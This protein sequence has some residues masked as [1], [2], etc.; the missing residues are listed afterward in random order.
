[1]SDRNPTIPLLIKSTESSE[2]LPLRDSD[3]IQ[4]NILAGFL[5]DH[6]SFL[7]LKF[8]DTH[9]GREWLK[10]LLPHIATT[11]QVAT[12][13]T[14]FSNA[15]RA[16][17]GDDPTGL[18]AWWVNIGFTYHGLVT[19]ARDVEGDLNNSQFQLNAFVEGPGARALLLGDVSVSDPSNWLI[20]GPKQ[21]PIDI[22]LTIAAD[23]VSDLELKLN[24][25]RSLAAR[26]EIIVIFEQRGDTLPGNRKGHEHFGFKDGISQPGIKGFDPV[27]SPNNL[28]RSEV[29]GR[30]GSQLINAGEFVLGYDREPVE[31]GDDGSPLHSPKWMKDGSFQVFRRLVQDVP[32]W[33]AQILDQAGSL[34]AAEPISPDLLAAKLIG[35]W[36]SGTPLTEAPDQDIRSAKDRQQDNNFDFEDDPLGERVPQFSHI[37]KMNPRSRIFAPEKRRI[38]R[39]GIP[40]GLP[41][42]PAS[43]RG[44]GIDAERGLLFNAYMASIED[45]FEFLQRSWANNSGFPPNNP[46]N[47]QAG[48]DPVIGGESG[49]VTLRRKGAATT[50]LDFRRFV[51]TSGAVYAFAPSLSTLRL[52]AKGELKSCENNL[53]SA[54]L[55]YPLRVDPIP[56]FDP[57]QINDIFTD[58]LFQNIFEGL[59]T[60]DYNDQLAPC[61][62]N[63][64]ESGEDGITYTFYLQPNAMFHDP[65]LRPVLAEDVKYSFERALWPETNSGSAFDFLGGIVGA[66]DV[67]DGRTR[68]LSGIKI[69]NA[70]TLSITLDHPRGY[71]LPALS[72]SCCWIVCKE[73]IEANGGILDDKAAI[74]TGPFILD[75]FESG[76]YV[77]LKANRHYYGGGPY[78]ERIER[79]V[80]TDDKQARELFDNDEIDICYINL[81]DYIALQQ[82]P[83][84]KKEAHLDRWLDLVYLVMH[85]GIESAFQDTRVRMAIAKA[86]DRDEIVRVL[87]QGYWIR[88]DDLFP[89]KIP[90]D[91]EAENLF[92]FDPAAASQL[93]AE[94]GYEYGNGFPKLTLV[95]HVDSQQKPISPII[96]DHLKRYLHIDVEVEYLESSTYFA[97]RDDQKLAFYVGGMVADYPDPQIVISNQ[98]RS[99]SEHNKVGYRNA[100]FDALCN[101]A[102][103]ELDIEKRIPLYQKAERIARSEVAVLPL[104]HGSFQWLQKPHILGF[105]YNSINFQAHRR[106]RIARNEQNILRYVHRTKEFV[107]DPHLINDVFNTELFQNIYEGLVSYDYNNELV[108]ELARYWEISENGRTY[109]FH[110]R[111]DARFHEPYDRAITSADVKYSLER[112]LSRDVKS[113]SAEMLK[114]IE[115]AEPFMAGKTEGLDGVKILDEQTLSITLDQP[116]N[117]FPGLLNLPVSWVLCREAI[118]ADGGQITGRGI[119]GTGPFRLKQLQKD[120][121]VLVANKNYHQDPPYIKRIERPIVVDQSEERS[122]YDSGQ[123]DICLITISDYL[124]AKEDA[125]LAGEAHLYLWADLVY[126]VMHSRLQAEF[127]DQDVRLAFAKAIDRDAIIY[128]AGRGTWQ[129]ADSILPQVIRGESGSVTNMAYDPDA[130]RYHLAKAGFPKGGGFP[131]LALIHWNDPQL[132]D[133]A[134]MIAENIIQN[135]GIDVALYEKEASDYFSAKTEGRMPFYL[136]GWIADYLDP[137]NFLSVILRTGASQNQVGYSNA[138]FDSLCDKAD[139]TFDEAERRRLYI[140][141]EQMA[142]EDVAILPLLSG[143]F[144]LLIKPYIRGFSYNLLNLM[145]H[146]KTRIER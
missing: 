110:L 108:P 78:L 131:A 106:T 2:D 122:L 138:I 34:P 3:E 87:G 73:A 123:I 69:L 71:F 112:A 51:H 50:K 120:R 77:N 90:G 5:K 39:R 124:K 134:R 75:K 74:G 100:Q 13:N 16:R 61:L 55:R 99:D 65:F 7:F 66:G 88:A 85:P 49:S 54:I 129:R 107:V 45:Q 42:D 31:R 23:E 29:F 101:E 111:P 72:T 17:G 125:A 26:Y 64:W 96:A 10:E 126:L 40:Y 142:L 11:R 14:Q 89:P 59:L 56:S 47:Q 9:S 1:M 103:A 92:A 33:W 84:L 91:R 52:I 95:G 116:R 60:F 146:K 8:T 27:G 38:L 12:F 102:D 136:A 130:A 76:R 128:A 41:F 67:R 22:I 46:P 36:R 37:R 25:M 28:E 83:V 137:H 18:A 4:G 114:V 81:S 133:I 20:G 53:P 115:G 143:N 44:Q 118:E 79:P 104:L 62:A 113:P 144:K 135:L 24:E 121:A 140:Q 15:R 63:R 6:Q 82:N 21:Q 86:I 94:A 127:A 109:I 43:G 117:Y 58:E 48:P 119:I 35:R 57:T 97:S 145:P 141:A 93:L 19:L 80:I 98:L 132:G 139:V 32:S 68:E 70:L 30:P 105:P